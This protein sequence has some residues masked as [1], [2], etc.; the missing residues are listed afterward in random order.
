MWIGMQRGEKYLYEEYD[1]FGTN[2]GRIQGIGGGH[3]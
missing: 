1:L 2:G 3:E